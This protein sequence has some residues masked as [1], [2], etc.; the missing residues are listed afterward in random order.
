MQLLRLVKALKSRMQSHAFIDFTLL[1][2][3]NH[4]VDNSA[5]SPNHGGLSGL[6]YSVAQSDHRFRVR[7]I[8]LSREDLVSAEQQCTLPGMIVSEAPSDRGEVV[9]LQAGLRYKQRF[10]KLDWQTLQAA[11]PEAA[12]L[13]TGGVYVLLGG[14]GTVGAI[15]TRYL[16]QKYQANVVWLGRRALT[17]PAVQEQLHAFRSVD[18]GCVPLYIQADVTDQA[19]MTQ[20]VKEIKQHHPCIHGAIFSAL[21]FKLDN[22]IAKT[23]EEDF[24]EVLDT[25]KKG[26]QYF[27]HAFKDENLDFMCYFSSVQS[28]FF[29]SSRESAG[30]AAGI[31]SADTFVHAIDHDSTFPVGIINWGYWEASL[32][33]TEAE[34]HLPGH[35]DLIS[36]HDGCQFFDGFVPMLRSGLI[37]QAVCLGVSKAI[38]DFMGCDATQMITVNKPEADSLIFS[39]FNENEC[40]Q[41]TC[42]ETEIERLLDKDFNNE[43]KQWL[44]RLLFSQLQQLRIFLNR[45]EQRDCTTWQQQAGV[46]KKYERWWREC[47]LGLLETSGYVQCEGERVEVT[48]HSPA[49]EADQLWQGWESFQNLFLD[50][51]ERKPCARLIGELSEKPDA[52][53]VR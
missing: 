34:K 17:S 41:A 16:I 44:P 6:G 23:S 14:A 28:F 43:L 19:S 46:I 29:I 3:D 40:G 38:E 2:L 1:T 25:K 37:K 22:S 15:I 32:A 52:N 9:K 10:F 20:A 42:E 12:G 30:Y 21:V 7:N 39:L 33:G 36:D 11:Q 26:A 50:K 13:K 49:D 4:R 35:Y 8:D 47:C 48:H 53:P 27:Y 18:E 24:N 31:T 51:P 5:T 45:G